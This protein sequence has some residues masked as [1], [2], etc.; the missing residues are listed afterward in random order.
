ML[1]T[2]FPAQGLLSL[3]Q[4]TIQD[5]LS[6]VAL[7]QWAGPSHINHKSGKCLIDLPTARSGGGIFSAKLPSS[8][9]TLSCVRLTKHSS[10]LSV[11]LC[12]LLIHINAMNFVCWSYIWKPSELN[13][14]PRILKTRLWDLG[15]KGHAI[16]RWRSH[17]SLPSAFT[18]LSF[19]WRIA[20]A[21]PSTTSALICSQPD[22]ISLSHTH[23]AV[24]VIWIWG[25]GRRF[26]LIKSFL[27]PLF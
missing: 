15:V 25:L 26:Y 9:M 11:T 4:H 19:S 23:S 24:N 1:L 7:P 6:S 16:C 12:S 10:V 21:E 27:Y 14:C 5:C 20:V 17:F 13:E 3:L 2:G 18:F 8:Q 22:T